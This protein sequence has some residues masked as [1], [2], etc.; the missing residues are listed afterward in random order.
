MTDEL[1]EFPD[2]ANFYQILGI[3]RTATA[4][5]LKIAYRRRALLYHPDRHKEDDRDRAAETFKRISRAYQ[6][7]IDDE[8]RRRYDAALARGHAYRESGG[9]TSTAKLAEILA[10]ILEY[11]H[12]FASREELRKLDETLRE[13]VQPR[14]IDDLQEQIIG[15]W[16]MSTAPP[17][18]EHPGSF[19]AGAIIVTNLRVLLPFRYSWEEVKGNTR[20]RYSGAAM[21]TY[22][23]PLIERVVMASERRVR[24]KLWVELHHGTGVARFRSPHCDLGKLLLVIRL[25]GIPVETQ[26]TDSRREELLWA[27][28]TPWLQ[29]AIVATVVLVAAVAVGLVWGDWWYTP[30]DFAVSC[31]RN[32]VWQGGI[33][34]VASVSASRIWRWTLAYEAHEPF[35]AASPDSTSRDVAVV[36]IAPN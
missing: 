8:E 33:I 17:G 13:I 5:E 23:L 25:W 35:A 10:D 15:I 28:T 31:T 9:P 34:L 1:A 14:L 16:T 29:S 18:V 30:V 12:V 36:T 6:V 20:Y 27:V 26:H 19:Q 4:E 22:P 24:T 3:D 7:L 2:D 21:P 11:E 32:G